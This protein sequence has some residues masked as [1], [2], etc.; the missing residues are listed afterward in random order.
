MVLLLALQVRNWS[1]YPR[2]IPENDDMETLRVA[3]ASAIIPTG[4]QPITDVWTPHKTS[5][6]KPLRQKKRKK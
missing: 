6:D 2:T 1:E 3:T 4:S 5:E